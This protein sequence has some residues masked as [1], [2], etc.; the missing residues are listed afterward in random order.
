M[1]KCVCHINGYQIKD[2]VAR[3]SVE[4]L[5]DKLT[6]IENAIKEGGGGAVTDTTLLQADVTV[7]KTNVSGL[8]EDVSDIQVEVIN[9]KGNVTTLQA[10][11]AN[12]KANSGNSGSQYESRITTLEN[13][14]KNLQTTCTDLDNLIGNVSTRVEQLAQEH[15]TV[16]VN[17]ADYINADGTCNYL[18][19]N[20]KLAQIA[21]NS[22]G[23]YARPRIAFYNTDNNEDREFFLTNSISWQSHCD[24]V[25]LYENNHYGDVTKATAI[26]LNN[27]SYCK[28]TGFRISS[29][30]S[31]NALL[32]LYNCN[33]IIFEDCE[34]TNDYAK[35]VLLENCNN[36]YFERCYLKGGNYP[37]QNP[38]VIVK[39]TASATGRR[40]MFYQTVFIQASDDSTSGNSTLWI[41]GSESTNTK[42][43]IS[44]TACY[45]DYY[46]NISSNYVSAGSGITHIV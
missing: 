21:G 44:C 35:C 19:F 29:L 20:A 8:Q 36:I 34:F 45:N 17:L 11:V 38:I 25:W 24:Y 5:N 43:L 9:V 33:N 15:C 41:D 7:L 30:P 4:D 12:L 18:A 27:T 40:I 3:N 26:F 23:E 22:K 31:E 10:D 42:L 37:K 2:S 16:Y 32:H 13:K 46:I 6:V 28:F 39:D 14:V 1:A